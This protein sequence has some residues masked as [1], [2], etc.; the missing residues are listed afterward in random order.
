[1]N[2]QS[3]GRNTA[4]M[5]EMPKQYWMRWLEVELAENLYCLDL[6]DKTSFALVDHKMH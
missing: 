6:G 1:M 5:D 3:I 2:E 4:E